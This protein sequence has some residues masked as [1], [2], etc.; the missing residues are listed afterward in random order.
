MTIMPWSQYMRIETSAGGTSAGPRDFVRAAHKLLSEEGRTRAARDV[1]HE[2][3]RSG[4][5]K[6]T[7][8]RQL[9]EKVQNGEVDTD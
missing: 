7:Y 4:L 5:S 2:W 1:R 3:L 6:L 8:G 9:S